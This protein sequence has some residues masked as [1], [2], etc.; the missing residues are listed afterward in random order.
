MAYTNRSIVFAIVSVFILVYSAL[1]ALTLYSVHQN[2][3]SSEHF[4]VGSPGGD[5]S[6]YILLAHT[7]LENGRF[8]FGPTEPP[9]TFRTPG[10]PFFIALMLFLTGSIIFMPIGQI[11]LTACSV[12]LIFLVGARFFNRGIGLAAAVL[13]ALDP[14]LSMV[15]FLS[16][17]DTLFVFVLLLSIYVLTVP[18]RLGLSRAFC[19]GVLIGMLALVRPIGLYI[20]PLIVLWLLWEGRGEWK[21]ALQTMALFLIGMGLVVVP[22]MARNYAHYGSASISS[23]GA[24][25]LLFYNL[26][27]FEHE[28]TGIS[29]NAVQ[30]AMLK[31]MNATSTDPL[32]SLA[33]S[34]REKSVARTYLEAHPF[35]YAAYH[36]YKTI[37]FY[38]GSSIDAATEA[39]H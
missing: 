18:E 24:Y 32:L 35:Q 27:D 31:Q 30:V 29:K 4:I 12:E 21:R 10:Y 23:I 38:I 15:M 25:N 8:S 37:P 22:W 7:L 34:G 20:F 13:F 33:F 14:Y 3:F 5:G 19:G 28:R 17:S 11:I 16:A 6:Q 36:L 39:L 2:G 26:T 9:D 1:Y